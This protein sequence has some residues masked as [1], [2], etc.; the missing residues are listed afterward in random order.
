MGYN[1][2]RKRGVSQVLD[3]LGWIRFSKNDDY[4]FQGCTEIMEIQSISLCKY[5]DDVPLSAAQ[6]STDTSDGSVKERTRYYNW[7]NSSNKS[8][9]KFSV[10]FYSS[11]AYFSFPNEFKGGINLLL[12]VLKLFETHGVQ[13][14]PQ[15]VPGKVWKSCEKNLEINAGNP[16][17]RRSTCGFSV[18]VQPLP[19]ACYTLGSS[20]PAN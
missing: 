2:K 15:I 18:E 10:L 11:I 3:D 17:R 6:K 13:I 20:S 16:V 12:Q 1:F 14:F 5:G 4:S 7:H 9:R 8:I 19:W